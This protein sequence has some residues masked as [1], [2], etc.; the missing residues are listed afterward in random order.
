MLKVDRKGKAAGEFTKD[1]E[2]KMKAAGLQVQRVFTIDQEIE[3]LNTFFLIMLGIFSIMSVLM[4][5]I[6]ALGIA[7]TMGMNV[8]ERIREIGVM[9]AIGADNRQIINIFL[10][11][12]MLIS[13]ISWAFSIVFALLISYP[14]CY[15][16]GK[17]MF[18][19]P[20][21]Y[22]FSLKGALIWLVCSLAFGALASIAP[23]KQASKIS[24]RDA[25]AYE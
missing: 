22:V 13:F 21:S 25:I 4:G 11:E 6:G 12:G 20:L 16:I 18:Q 9:R 17:I 19:S 5:F 3:S 24:V 7:G 2:A 10:F 8:I 1:L 14:A 23:A 15:F